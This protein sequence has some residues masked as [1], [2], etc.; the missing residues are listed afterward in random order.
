MFPA[1][2]FPAVAEFAGFTL[3]LV[4]MAGIFA[5]IPLFG[6]KS[7]P[8]RVKVAAVFAMALVLFPVLR[9]RLPQLP[10]DPISLGLLVLGETLIGV[11]LGLLSQLLCSAVEFGG[12][13]IGMQMGFNVSSLFDP[14]MGTQVSTMSLLQNLLA[15]LL[16]LS[17]GIH[18]LF[19]RALVESYTLVPVGS[20][21]M[22]GGL[23][24]FLVAATAAVFVLA[25]KIAAP[26]MASL[27][28]AAVVLG[29]MARAFP[30]MNIFMLS[31]PLNIGVGFLILGISLLV[32]FRTL[33]S[34]FTNL[35]HQLAAL[36]RLLGG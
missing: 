34:A 26:V 23:L 3:V 25:L 31:F 1:V 9:G 11:T 4:R 28:A 20:W 14:T 13:I 2:P 35:E 17:L 16:F 29:I 21:H 27:L 12:Q 32:F 18:H 19:I 6:G 8:A 5:A 36:C 7:V 22:S 33:G 15:T 10:A 24:R 30:Q